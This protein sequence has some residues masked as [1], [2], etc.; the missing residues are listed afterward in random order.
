[1]KIDKKLNLVLDIEREDRSVVHVHHSPIS[2]DVYKSHWLFISKTVFGL[3]SEGFTPPQCTRNAHD[4]MVELIGRQ[5]DKFKDVDKTLL[6]EIWRLTNVL[7]P[8]ERGWEMVP[9]YEVMKGD[10]LSEDDI[11]EV[12]NYV[13]FFTSAS[14]VHGRAEL[15]GLYEMMA[16]SG[17]LTTAL[18]STEFMRSLP[19]STSAASTG[20]TEIPSFIPA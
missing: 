3:Y 12:K 5:P 14:R 4:A 8:G 20:A 7:V 19:T 2:K 13:C 17:V 6:A 16:E 1:M 9:F 10:W 11:D 15:Q 18:D